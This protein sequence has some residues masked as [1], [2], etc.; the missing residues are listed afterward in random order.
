MD[1]RALH[2]RRPSRALAADDPGRR[3]RYAAF[4]QAKRRL[5][6]EHTIEPSSASPSTGGAPR[7]SSCFSTWPKARRAAAE[8]R[9]GR[10]CFE[11]F[12]KASNR[13]QPR[14]ELR[15]EHTL[16]PKQL[17]DYRNGRRFTSSTTK[18]RC[19]ACRPWPARNGCRARRRTSSPAAPETR[20]FASF[21]WRRDT[22]RAR[23]APREARCTMATSRIISAPSAADGASSSITRLSC[24]R[25]IAR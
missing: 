4:I 23:R 3:G 17:E 14:L 12:L 20:A 25:V 16:E 19:P 22:A 9:P 8:L 21:S 2:A 1:R 13:S 11:L 15:F 6:E 5:E 7:R 18:S 10:Y 24:P